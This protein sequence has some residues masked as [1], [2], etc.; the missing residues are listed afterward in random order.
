MAAADFDGDGD[1]DLA[2]RNTDPS[3]L[4]FL[5]N[6]GRAV[7]S[8]QTTLA[9]HDPA[10]FIVAVDA[11]GDGDIDL[12]AGPGFRFLLNRGGWTFEWGADPV[13][14]SSNFA[15]GTG[16]LD[17]DGAPEII[18]G[19]SSEFEIYPNI[20]GGRLGTPW[21]PGSHPEGGGGSDSISYSV[22]G[23]A[24]ADFDDDG[25]N[26]IAGSIKYERSFV[27]V[28]LN[29][30]TAASLDTNGDGVPDECASEPFRRGDSNGDGGIDLSDAVYILR[31][32]FLGGDPLTCLKAADSNDDARVDVSDPVKILRV[33][34]L[35]EPQLPPPSDACGVDPTGDG[36]SCGAFE[37]CA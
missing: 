29:R 8:R 37:G 34:F 25:R 17:G 5:A 23:V 36:L 3:N 10:F 30:T 21:S 12:A 1:V 18:N 24:V 26:D 35:G 14:S 27:T 6:D 11:D 13:V 15:M 9:I 28:L 22:Q 20:G 16:D 31:S 19:I 4:T 2:I 7:F 32:L 33:L